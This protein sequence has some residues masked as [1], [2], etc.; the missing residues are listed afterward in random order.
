MVIILISKNKFDINLYEDHV[1][2]C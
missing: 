2:H 1:F